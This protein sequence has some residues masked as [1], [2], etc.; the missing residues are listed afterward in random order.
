[1]RP[2]DRPGGPAGDPARE[3]R[4]GTLPPMRLVAWCVAIA[5]GFALADSSIVILALPDILVEFDVSVT[6]VSW[7]LTAF[8]L[9]LA[10]AAVPAALLARRLQPAIVLSAGIGLFAAA[11]AVCAA[12]Q[13]LPPLLVAR[14]FQALGA[15][16]ILC[17]ALELLPSIVG[18]EAAARRLWTTAGIA[19]AAVGPAVGGLATQLISWR[20]IFLAQVPVI[21]VVGLVVRMR[22]PRASFDARPARPRI[23]A[24]AGLA[25]ASA[26]LTAALFLLVLLLIRGW[27]YSPIHAALIVS[28]MPVA[29]LA[30]PFVA[31]SVP[32]LARAAAGALL[33]SGGL[34]ALGL[35]PHE[36]TWWT[37]VP[38]LLIGLGLGW[39]ISALTGYALEGIADHGI[40]GAWTIAARHLGVVVG[41]LVLTP[42]FTADLS[43]ET[44]AAKRS[45]TAVILDAPLPFDLKLTL[46]QRI[47]DRVQQAQGAIPDIGPAFSGVEIPASS[48]R[49]A[50]EMR[51]HLSDQLSRAGTSAFHRSFLAAAGFA[52]ASAVPIGL[53]L[54]AGRGRR[55]PR[56]AGTV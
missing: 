2:P 8:N 30:A 17:A 20:S 45:G 46:A 52:L 53:A 37:V 15:A 14:G 49:A 47:I 36:G 7:V 51:A 19:G 28:V 10:L 29:A 31:R 6:A 16:A 4:T 32:P 18:S 27:L 24:L 21:L 3:H 44:D 56:H 54:A 33:L 13:S 50:A 12:A 48:R 9:V 26:A 38:Q 34:A 22:I 40:Q 11:S 23:D 41:I 25:L 43:T 42:I 39:V 35:L 55:R 5:V 1:M